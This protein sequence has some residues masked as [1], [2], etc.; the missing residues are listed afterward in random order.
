MLYGG[1]VI[2]IQSFID[3][4]RLCEDPWILLGTK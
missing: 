4:D 1:Y 2:I 3:W